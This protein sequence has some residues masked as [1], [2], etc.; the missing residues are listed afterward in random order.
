[1]PSRREL[2]LDAIVTALGASPAGAAT[3]AKPSSLTVHR[4][5]SLPLVRDI[6]PAIVVYVVEEETVAGPPMMRPLARRRTTVRLEHRVLVTGSASPDEALDPLLAWATQ[7]LLADPEWGGLAHDT[8][9]T[10]TEWVAVADED[11]QYAAAAQDF[12][13]DHITAAGDQTAA[14]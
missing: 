10:R 12:V 1:M 3:T 8:S 14:A 4:Q 5:R 13:L 9:E 11:R 6:L 7:Q 2:L